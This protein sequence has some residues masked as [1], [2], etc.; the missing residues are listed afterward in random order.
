MVST[1]SNRQK[2]DEHMVMLR[3]QWGDYETRMAQYRERNSAGKRKKLSTS[4]VAADD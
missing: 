3:S 2:L 1:K 4:V